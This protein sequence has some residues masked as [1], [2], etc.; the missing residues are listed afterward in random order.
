MNGAVNEAL[1][2]VKFTLYYRFARVSLACAH[3]PAVKTPAGQWSWKCSG[4]WF[5]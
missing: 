1:P 2:I 3:N 5:L 4:N